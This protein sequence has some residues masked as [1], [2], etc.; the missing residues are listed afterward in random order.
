VNV[1]RW[2]RS[3]AGHHSSAETVGLVGIDDANA[4]ITHQSSPWNRLAVAAQDPLV[5]RRSPDG[6]TTRWRTDAGR[7]WGRP[8]APR[9]TYQLVGVPAGDVLPRVAG[10]G[11]AKLAGRR[12][13]HIP[14]QQRREET[15]VGRSLEIGLAVMI[16]VLQPTLTERSALNPALVRR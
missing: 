10:V 4:D 3:A 11:Q 5:D 16:G 1:R 12:L 6:W 8:A 7:P 2:T 14:G 13:H 9:L 15:A